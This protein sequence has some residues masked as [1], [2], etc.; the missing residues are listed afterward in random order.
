MPAFDLATLLNFSH[1]NCVA[2][3]AFLIPANLFATAYTLF[4]FFFKQSPVQVRLAALGASS[5]GLL[6]ILHVL[7]WF[8]IGVITPVTFILNALAATCLLANGCAFALSSQTRTT[9]QKVLR[10]IHSAL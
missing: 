1:S 9:T 5:F 6:M 8:A 2:I 4:V 3:C 7:S 10:L